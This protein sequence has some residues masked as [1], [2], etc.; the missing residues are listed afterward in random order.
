MFELKEK[1]RCHRKAHCKFD[2]KI[3]CEN[4]EDETYV[5]KVLSA[6]GEKMNFCPIELVSPG[7][8]NAMEC[9]FNHDRET[10]NLRKKL[11]PTQKK[12]ETGEKRLCY[13]ELRVKGSCPYKDRCLFE[14]NF[15]E[16]LRE[17]A[18]LVRETKSK[19]SKCLSEFKEKGSCRYLEK[20][21][22]DHEITDAQREDVAMQEIMQKKFDSMKKNQNK[23]P[24]RSIT[25][26]DEEE[27]LITKALE[28]MD[29]IRKSIEQIRNR[30]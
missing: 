21:R 20:C 9:V 2:H 8:H 16:Q 26:R 11:P 3:T 5:K 6:H 25:R 14:H 27:D 23:P 17:D 7:E 4:R 10:S 22:F 13:R 29:N 18:N 24:S 28:D 30:P 1:G 12:K 19:V 15:P